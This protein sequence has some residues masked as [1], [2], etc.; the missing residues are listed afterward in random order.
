LFLFKQKSC[1]IR[2]RHNRIWIA[3]QH[4]PTSV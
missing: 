1:S 3:L 4:Q 2:R